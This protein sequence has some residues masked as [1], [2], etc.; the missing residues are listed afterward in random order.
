MKSEILYEEQLKKHLFGGEAFMPLKEMLKMIPY[1][2]VGI[3]PQNLPY[4]FFEI[5]YHIWFTQND[6]LEYCLKPDYSAPKWPDD[7]WPSESSPAGPEAWERLQKDFFEDR[8]KFEELIT[9]GEK[10]LIVPVPSNRNHSIFRELL[11]VIEHSA[12]HTGQLFIILRLL[13]LK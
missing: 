13:G 10:E 12:Y 7:Y 9:S 5:F 11:L 6:I 3:K 4:S 1:D 8:E 2:Q